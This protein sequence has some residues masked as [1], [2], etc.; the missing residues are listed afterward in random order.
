MHGESG[1]SHRCC[2][3][4]NGDKHGELSLKIIRKSNAENFNVRFFTCGLDAMEDR[5]ATAAF[6][7]EIR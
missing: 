5:R 4:H 2:L 6:L 7:R 1:K 3:L